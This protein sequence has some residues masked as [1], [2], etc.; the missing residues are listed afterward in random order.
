M[1]T[2]LILERTSKAYVIRALTLCVSIA[3]IPFAIHRFAVG[4]FELAALDTFVVIFMAG[5]YLY[6]QKTRNLDVASH[7]IATCFLTTEIITVAINGQTQLVWC[8]PATVGIMYLIPLTRAIMFN[9]IGLFAVILILGSNLSSGHLAAFVA[10]IV[11]MTVFT[12]VFALRNQ[13]Q[14]DQLET[15]SMKDPLTNT[16]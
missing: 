10:S 6:V 9:V 7:V 1:N 4:E 11:S 2:T 15:L 12:F 13:M 8:Y 5:I 14:K 3:L 16:H